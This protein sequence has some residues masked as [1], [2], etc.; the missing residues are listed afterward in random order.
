MYIRRQVWRLV[1]NWQHYTTTASH[2]SRTH[3]MTDFSGRSEFVNATILINVIRQ[4]W[5]VITMIKIKIIATK[6]GQ[7]RHASRST[8][9]GVSA[10]Y[11]QSR[12]SIP[13]FIV[14]WWHSRASHSI[15]TY[16]GNRRCSNW[17]V[18]TSFYLWSNQLRYYKIYITSIIVI[19]II[20]TYSGRKS[21]LSCSKKSVLHLFWKIYSF[22]FYSTNWINCIFFEPPEWSCFTFFHW[23]IH[24]LYLI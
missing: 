12:F 4:L 16:C 5:L 2:S 10:I 11:M 20:L 14:I 15:I 21:Q 24:K 13:Q 8:I 23:L 1:T 17:S 9:C 3:L 19:N 18:W 22:W 6:K 7:R